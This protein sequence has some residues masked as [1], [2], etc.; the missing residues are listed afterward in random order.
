MRGQF[1]FYIRTMQDLADAVDQVGFLPLFSNNIPGFSAEE[2]TDPRVLWGAEDGL[3]EWKGP[4]IQQARCAYGKFLGGKATFISRAWFPDFANVR[5]DGY[6]FDARYDE[7]LAPRRDKVLFDLIDTHAPIVSLKLKEIGGYG[8]DGVKGFDSTMTRLQAQCYVTVSNFSYRIGKN[9]QRKG[10]GL[11]EYN[12]PEKFLGSDFCE[13]VYEREPEE[14]RERVLEHLRGLLPDISS[15]R[16][17][18]LL[19]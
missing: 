11:A 5:R 12:T 14:S 15:K 10:W 17:E 19:G 6:D 4:V 7:G 9:G 1:D 18:K 3:W 13:R 2:H 8:K 16:L